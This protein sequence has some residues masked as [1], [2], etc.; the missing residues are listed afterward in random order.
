MLNTGQCE[1]V[2]YTHIS[3]ACDKNK[4]NESDQMRRWLDFQVHR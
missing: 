3:H 1:G 2:R 4:I